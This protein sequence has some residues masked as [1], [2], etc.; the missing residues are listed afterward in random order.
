MRRVTRLLP[1]LIPFICQ[2]QSN[3]N[4]SELANILNFE[5]E[6]TGH[7]PHGWGGGPSETIYTD[8]KVVHG[9]KWA[10]RL[11]RDTASGS[12][13]STITIGIP[14]DFAG[15][16]IEFRGFIKT[17]DVS[18]FAGSKAL[19]RGGLSQTLIDKSRR[20]CRLHKQSGRYKGVDYR[21]P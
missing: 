3:V 17:Q 9:G 6:Q 11:Q 1:I 21:Y 16:S 2:A 15:T 14:V 8:D 19:G 20:C 5:A 7:T 4:R 13:F 12:N 10:V 18:E